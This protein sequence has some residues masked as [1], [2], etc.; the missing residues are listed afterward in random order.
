MRKILIFSYIHPNKIGIFAQ[1]KHLHTWNI[2]QRKTFVGLVHFSCISVQWHHLGSGT[3]TD[4]RSVLDKNLSPPFRITS[5]GQYIRGIS[6]TPAALWAGV[7]WRW[8]GKDWK[9][10]VTYSTVLKP[11]SPLDKDWLLLPI[12]LSLE[13]LLLCLLDVLRWE[14]TTEIRWRAGW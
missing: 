6:L 3:D 1:N 9:W 13:P 12:Y 2:G 8:N 11:S 4:L 5:R 10:N 7:F 14:M